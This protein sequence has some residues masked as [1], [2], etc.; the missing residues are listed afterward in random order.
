VLLAAGMIAAVL[1]L[2]WIW[3]GLKALALRL[4]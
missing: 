1:M 4:R 3:G 2:R